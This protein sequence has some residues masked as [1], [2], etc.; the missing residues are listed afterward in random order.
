MSDLL[1][2]GGIGFF[3]A[4]GG[5]AASFFGF[6]AKISDLE[7]RMDKISD[8]VVYEDTFTVKHDSIEQR[9]DSH[10]SMLKE[11]RGDIKTLIGKQ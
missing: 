6:K 5:A 8:S 1:T 7:K 10:E 4:I 11:I 3:S 2:T 9:F